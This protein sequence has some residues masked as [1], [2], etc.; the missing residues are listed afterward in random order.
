M[1]LQLK[2]LTARGASNHSTFMGNW[3]T[4]ISLIHPEDKLSF[5]GMRIWGQSKISFC[6]ICEWCKSREMEGKESPRLSKPLAESFS[7]YLLP[8]IKSS[9]T[10]SPFEL[11][12][13]PC[14]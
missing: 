11:H 5:K 1:L 13:L 9:W 2:S 14:E 6:R 10:E 7:A 4:V 8:V 3:A 12:I